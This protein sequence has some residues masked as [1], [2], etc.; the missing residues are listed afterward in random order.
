ML[1]KL[2]RIVFLVVIFV[3]IMTAFLVNFL[4]MNDLRDC[5]LSETCEKV[6]AIV[7]VSGGRTSDRVEG[8]VFLYKQGLAEY[9]IMS[10]AAADENSPSN[11]ETMK[12][13]AVRMGVPEEKILTEEFSKDTKENAQMTGEIIRFRDMKSITIVTAE[14]HQRRTYLEFRQELGD[15]IKIYNYPAAKVGSNALLWWI[16]PQGWWLAISEAVKIGIFYLR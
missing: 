10:G 12:E 8:G 13:Q 15:G 6:D 5:L 9:M 2:L 4:P 1:G 14:Y 3:V 7:V 11:A 16:T